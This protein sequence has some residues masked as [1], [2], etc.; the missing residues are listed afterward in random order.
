M[1]RIPRHHLRAVIPAFVGVTAEQPS[2]G[3]NPAGKWPDNSWPGQGGVRKRKTGRAPND[4]EQRR[5]LMGNAQLSHGAP[6]ILFWS[7]PNAVGCA[8]A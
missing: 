8:G 5:Q 1:P 2:Q 7:W 6:D 3:F 4:G